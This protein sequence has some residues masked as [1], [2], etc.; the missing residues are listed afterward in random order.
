MIG[1]TNAATIIGSGGSTAVIREYD[2]SGTWIKPAGLKFLLAIV[3]GGGGGGQGGINGAGQGGGLFGGGGNICFKIF[4]NKN[5][6]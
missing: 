2:S 3:V 1:K 6:H 4:A 5:K